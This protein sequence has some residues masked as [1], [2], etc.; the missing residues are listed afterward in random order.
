[1]LPSGMRERIGRRLWLS[2]MSGSVRQESV[3]LPWP[4]TLEQRHLENCRV[5]A[6][7]EILIAKLHLPQG[8]RI[9]EVGVFKG[10][11]SRHLFDTCHP[12][13]LHLIDL[14]LRSHRIAERFQPEIAAGRIILHEG[15]SSAVVRQFSEGYFD[16]IYVD[17]DHSYDGVRRDIDAAAARIAERGVLIF[18][19][20]TYWSPCE[21]MRYG[22]MQAVNEFCLNTNWEVAYFA[23]D[24]YM[25]CDI[26]IH[27]KDR[28]G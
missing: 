2:V 23:L 7:R 17:G 13:E 4:P 28:S 27:R 9:A 22:V 8:C 20:Y 15:D 3:L 6:S 1:M 19:D 5:A 18:N 21:C 12:A 14:D 11:F 24:G 10:D 16:A 25:Y 26:A